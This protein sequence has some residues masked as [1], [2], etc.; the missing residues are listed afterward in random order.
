MKFV[1]SIS[2]QLGK[3][4]GK[5]V[6]NILQF[7]PNVKLNDRSTEIGEITNESCKGSTYKAEFVLKRN[8]CKWA[9]DEKIFISKLHGN[10]GSENILDDFDTDRAINISEVIIPDSS[11]SHS[12]ACISTVENI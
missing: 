4:L 8:Q 11:L 12:S 3:Y 2:G 1:V 10:F 5:F 7:N 6:I 9:K